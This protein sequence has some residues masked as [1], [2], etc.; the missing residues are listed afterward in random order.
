MSHASFLGRAHRT[1]F[2]PSHSDRVPVSRPS[3]HFAGVMIPTVFAW[4]STAFPFTR[5]GPHRPNIPSKQTRRDV[6][7]NVVVSFD[8]RRRPSGWPWTRVTGCRAKNEAASAESNSSLQTALCLLTRA[9]ID[10]L[11]E[12][13]GSRPPSADHPSILLG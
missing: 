2:H 9:S 13:F 4:G 8:A 11:S 7:V 1:M 6:A 10:T 12:P 3:Q 5:V